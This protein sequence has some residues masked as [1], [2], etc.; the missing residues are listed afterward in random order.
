MSV[1]WVWIATIMAA[2]VAW[3]AFVVVPE[4]KQ[5]GEA[6]GVMVQSPTLSGYACV[7]KGA[8]R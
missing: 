4:F 2:A 1:T 3:C 7:E 5:C 8:R 6:A